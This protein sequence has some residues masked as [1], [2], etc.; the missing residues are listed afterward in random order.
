MAYEYFHEVETI[1][2]RHSQ[3]QLT[4]DLL[5]VFRR[6]GFTLHEDVLS[7][8]REGAI[9]PWQNSSIVDVEVVHNDQDVYDF[10]EA[11]WSTLRLKY[12]FASLPFEFVDQFIDV[13]YAL[14]QELGT[15]LT[16]R[17]RNIDRG[18]LKAHF[19]RFRDEVLTTT[20]EDVGSEG[21]AILIYSTYPRRRL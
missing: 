18:E 13:A 21:L 4:S 19:E 7:L 6:R 2:L 8:D 5:P 1:D 10:E 16:F 3:A 9:P 15:S 11:L 20:G 14:S 12:L 17:G